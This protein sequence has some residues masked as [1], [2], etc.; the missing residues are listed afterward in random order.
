MEILFGIAICLI[1]LA[2]LALCI[3]LILSVIEDAKRL[4]KGRG[5]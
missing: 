4:S 2:L 3:G 1:G 5:K